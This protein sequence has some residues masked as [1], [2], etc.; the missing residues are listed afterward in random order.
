MPGT[1]AR[2]ASFRIS[3]ATGE[4]ASINKIDYYASEVTAAGSGD[5]ST[6]TFKKNGNVTIGA[7]VSPAVAGS[8]QETGNADP[9]TNPLNDLAD[10][11]TLEVWIGGQ[12]GTVDTK[13]RGLTV[14]FHIKVEHVP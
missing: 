6:L 9:G 5:K 8:W 11:D 13:L 10:E 4:R 3:L 1:A 7:T 14:V 2:V 12:N